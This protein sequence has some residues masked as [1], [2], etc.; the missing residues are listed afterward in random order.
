LYHHRLEQVNP[1]AFEREADATDEAILREATRRYFPQGNGSVLALRT[2]M[3]TNTPD[4]HFIVDVLLGDAR[5]IV[6]S[7][8][9][10]HGFKFAS[11][12]GEVLADLAATGDT[13]HDISLL[14]LDRFQA[15]VSGEE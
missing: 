3:F 2:C 4:E 12:M 9:S 13:G 10:G 5:V 1:D 6:A 15:A 7:P 8:C 14:R 11:V